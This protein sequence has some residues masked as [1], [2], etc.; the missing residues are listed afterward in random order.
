M[1]DTE[2]L[3]SEILRENP[4]LLLS[5]STNPDMVSTTIKTTNEEFRRRTKQNAD[6]I[7]SYRSGFKEHTIKPGDLQPS[8]VASGA[9]EK[10]TNQKSNNN[11]NNKQK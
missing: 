10:I 5:A 6:V 4:D 1:Q 11:N 7:E 3:G 9:F 2:F 8:L